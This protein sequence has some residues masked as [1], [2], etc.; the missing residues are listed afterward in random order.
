MDTAG[1]DATDEAVASGRVPADD[2]A[3]AGESCPVSDAPE[4][5]LASSCL[6]S[7]APEGSLAS[8]GLGNVKT[9]LLLRSAYEIPLGSWPQWPRRH[10]RRVWLLHIIRIRRTLQGDDAKGIRS[11]H[12]DH[13]C[14][15][16]YAQHLSC[17]AAS[18]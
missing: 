9:A 6:V 15:E 11:V 3:S 1:V 14:F 10:V 18:P 5:S 2:D 12:N 8:F 16:F 4:G 7:D 13:V 17:R